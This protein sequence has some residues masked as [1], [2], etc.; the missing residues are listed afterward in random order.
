ML[1]EK[2]GYNKYVKIIYVHNGLTCLKVIVT[3]VIS[4]SEGYLPMLHMWVCCAP[5]MFIALAP[6]R[7]GRSVC[8]CAKKT[9]SF[10]AI[11]SDT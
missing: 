1:Y 2:I 11:V 6:F 7:Q 3:V 10:A 5:R 9:I 8:C 4:S